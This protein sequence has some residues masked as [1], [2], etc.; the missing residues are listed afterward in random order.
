[1][2]S[3]ERAGR[4]RRAPSRAEH[5]AR[6]P[7]CVT[8]WARRLSAGPNRSAGCWRLSVDSCVGGCAHLWHGCRRRARHATHQCRS[9]CQA[10]RRRTGPP[11][12]APG[13]L[14]MH[15]H[16]VGLGVG[17]AARS[18]RSSAAPAAGRARLSRTIN[19][20]DKARKEVGLEHEV[21]LQDL[22]R[23]LQAGDVQ[24][25]PRETHPGPDKGGRLPE[26]AD[27]CARLFIDKARAGG[28]R[29]VMSPSLKSAGKLSTE[30][31]AAAK[32]ATILGSVGP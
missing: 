21:A 23:Y 15:S 5:R 9:R 20:P 19:A 22:R 24:Q 18:A 26:T 10:S 17:C 27:R 31:P 13:S 8:A 1:V 11:A 16:T 12:T 2:A 14:H 7:L 28:T 6:V 29:L 30:R 25:C 4:T 3:G 32:R